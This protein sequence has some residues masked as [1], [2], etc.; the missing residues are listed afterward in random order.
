M[1]ENKS[2]QVAI[3]KKSRRTTA[4]IVGIPIAIKVFLIVLLIFFNLLV[5]VCLD[6]SKRHVHI[7][8]ALA[9]VFVLSGRKDT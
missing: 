6:V 9:G 4:Y 5:K 7:V 2:Y 8:Y 1:T 3:P